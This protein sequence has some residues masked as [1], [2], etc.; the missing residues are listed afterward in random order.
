MLYLFLTGRRSAYLNAI[1]TVLHFPQNTIYDLKYNV[2]NEKNVVHQSAKRLDYTVGE[3]TLILF[4]NEDGKYVPLRL[5][6]LQNCNLED[7]QAYYS[8]Q[9]TDYC[10]M[11][12]ESDFIYF[13]NKLAPEIIRK[14]VGNNNREGILAFRDTD[15]KDISKVLMCTG[16]SWIQTVKLL[17]SLMSKRATFNQHYL[18]FT[19]MEVRKEDD[20]NCLDNKEGRINLKSGKCYKFHMSYYI[21]EFNCFPME[22]IL[23]NFYESEKCI[24][25]LENSEFLLSRQNKIDIICLPRVKVS[26]N[27]KAV[28]GFVIPEKM[29]GNKIIQYVRTPLKLNIQPQVSSK[30]RIVIIIL[31]ILLLFAGNCMNVLEFEE[32]F[33][34]LEKV[35]KIAGS[36]IVSISTFGMVYLMGKPKL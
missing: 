8:V 7:G 31:C 27:K 25:M 19:K 21:P 24:G 28:M 9:L 36:A 35:W 14:E 32:K 10:H 20:K 33:S 3:E 13:I 6:K 34:N 15:D 18:I 26:E 29:V 22:S 5:G 2:M 30:W 11:R 17:G 1:F 4:D 23:L 12:S 16:D